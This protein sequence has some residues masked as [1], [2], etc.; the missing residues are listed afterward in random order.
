[1]HSDCKLRVMSPLTA[2]GA[3]AE[4]VVKHEPTDEF[5]PRRWLTRWQHHLIMLGCPVS[6]AVVIFLVTTAAQG[7]A[8]RLE[9]FAPYCHAGDPGLQ[10]DVK[11]VPL[12]RFAGVK[13][14]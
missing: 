2:G 14:R 6:D 10:D 5:V 9:G 3:G 8:E 7:F 13:F 11:V 4:I 1:M 12:Q